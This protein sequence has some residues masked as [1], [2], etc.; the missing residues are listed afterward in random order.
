MKNKY[1]ITVVIP[2]FNEEK[3]IEPL[4]KALLELRLPIKQILFVDDGSSDGTSVVLQNVSS[5]YDCVEFISL[6]RNFGHQAAIKAGFDHA[7]GDCVVTMDGDMQHPPELIYQMV[8]IWQEGFDV[9]QT[10]R[11]CEHDQNYFKK[12]TSSLFYKAINFCAGVHIEKGTADFRLLDAKIIEIC[13]N[14]HEDTFFWRGIIPWLGFEQRFV[15]YVPQTRLYGSTKYTLKKML[16]LAW[17]GISSF[18]LLPLR[19][20]TLLGGVLFFVS[21]VYAVYVV[22]RVFLG[23]AVSGWG[24]LMIA[25]LGLGSVQM[26]LLGLLGEY[27]G[28]IFMSS[29]KRPVYIIKDASIKS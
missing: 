13:R 1:A 19:F 28:K 2:V 27:V 8:K 16:R 6:S 11:T 23:D 7:R 22:V 5:Q 10:R 20:A 25:V 24:S 15:D 17:E 18:S 3:N 29:K 12:H 4:L 26:I 9:V 14:M 21:L